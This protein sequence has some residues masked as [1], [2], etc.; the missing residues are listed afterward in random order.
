MMGLTHDEARRYVQVAADK[1]LGVGERKALEAHL[2][3]CVECRAYAAEMDALQL[4][5]TRALRAR[6]DRRRAPINLVKKA[7]IRAR[8]LH[9][10]KQAIRFVNAFAQ[11]SSFI[12]IAVLAVN[13]FQS[14]NWR[15]DDSL[16]QPA[17]ATVSAHSKQTLR[18]IPDF[19]L[20]SNGSEPVFIASASTKTE[21]QWD[22]PA[23]V[24]G[25]GH[26]Q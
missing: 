18:G 26:P 9:E 23:T 19:E 13:L 10:R 5:L 4:T 7:Q 12:V 20:Q 3:E 1:R 16:T 22:T 14:Q 15:L 2:A 24:V 11:V 8:H 21:S 6:W 25:R 17:P